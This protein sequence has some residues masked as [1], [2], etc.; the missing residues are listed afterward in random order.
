[1]GAEF[2]R[3]WAWFT[4]HNMRGESSRNAK[5]TEDQVRQ[6]RREYAAGKRGTAECHRYNIHPVRWNE[7]G[8]G[9]AWTHIPMEPREENT[10]A[11]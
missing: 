7:I 4:T 11:G 9:D 2:N 3:R 10:H 5:L 1:M 6:I 8:R